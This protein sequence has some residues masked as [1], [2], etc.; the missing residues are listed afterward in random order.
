MAEQR[1]QKAPVRGSIRRRGGS[2]QVRVYAGTDPETGKPHYLTE[3]HTDPKEAEKARTRLVAL[4]D[5]R[6][7]PLSNNT[8]AVAV[9]KWLDSRQAE[10]D[11]GE[12]SPT[13]LE[14]YRQLAR[15]HVIPVL[16]A[17]TM[18]EL[19]RQLVPTAEGLYA[20][21]LR[22]KIRC[23]KKMTT[24]HYPSGRANSR[25]LR[26]P[27]LDRH[28]CG[29]R[30]KPH[31]CV[32]MSASRL[33]TIHS[34]ITGT[35]ATAHRWRW[36]Q[37]NPAE[38]IK[39]PKASKPRPKA[40]STEEVGR[41]VAAAFD[42]DADWGTM[43]WLLLVTGVRR[44]ELLRWQLQDVDFNRSMIFVDSTKT[45]GT[46]RWVA[47]D[48]ATMG[49]LEALRARIETR[50]AAAGAAVTGEEYLHSYSPDHSQPGS[51]SYFSH[52][53]AKMGAAIGIKTHPHALRH[54]AATEL[55]AGGVDVVAV[56]RRLGHTKPS[57]TTDFYAAWRPEI[58]HRAAAILTSNVVLPSQLGRARVERDYSAEQPNRT[59][60][61]L[62]ARICD[63][64]RRTGWGPKRIREHLAVEEISIA[65][66]TIW[67]VL[68]RNRHRNGFHFD[69]DL[70]L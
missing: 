12:L 24:E 54:Y 58:D 49:L 61:A 27:E 62:E 21:L 52:R 22:C 68:T 23:G 37:E 8:F 57:T 60:P 39:A 44:S 48:H 20:A 29:R 2:L 66:S 43:V 3:T 36:I 9:R 25:I 56:A 6:K 67:K 65:E 10:V 31:T 42:M 33:R 14:D 34:I 32:R 4:A 70:E 55:V 50:L 5:A 13:T 40:P 11:A 38:R 46:S 16:G 64:R 18:G 63:L 35:C 15:D 47:L 7:A 28:T 19:D 41:L 51:K 59:D 26:G 17:I 1:S 69:Q 45:D 53:F 30:C